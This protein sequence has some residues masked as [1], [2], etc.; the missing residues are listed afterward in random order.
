MRK[1]INSVKMDKNSI[2]NQNGRFEVGE[3]PKHI[4]FDGYI[5]IEMS[6]LDVI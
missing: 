1:K 3:M 5:A 4:V 2:M 6:F